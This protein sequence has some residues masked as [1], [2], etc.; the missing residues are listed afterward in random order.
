[1]TGQGRLA[2]WRLRVPNL[3]GSVIAAAGN[4][5]SIGALRHWTDPEIVRSHHTNQQNKRGKL[6]KTYPFECPVTVDSHLQKNLIKKNLLARVPGHRALVNVPLETFYIYVISSVYLSTT[7]YLFELFILQALKKGT[8]FFCCCSGILIK[9]LT[10]ASGR[11]ASTG[12]LQIAS[13]KS[14][15]FCHDCR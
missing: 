2:I 3:D 14:W 12:I 15:W 4:L 13:P 1:M 10:V 8:C 5:L 6:E 7:S 11:S 9:K